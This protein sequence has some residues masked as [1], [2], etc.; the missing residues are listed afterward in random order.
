MHRAK[1]FLLV[2]AAVSIS[3]SCVEDKEF[4][5]SSMKQILE[6]SSTRTAVFVSFADKTL[7]LTVREENQFRLLLTDY[8]KDF[9]EE[10]NYWIMNDPM[11]PTHAPDLRVELYLNITA[12]ERVRWQDLTTVGREPDLCLHVY[13]L[14]PNTRDCFLELKANVTPPPKKI[15][16]LH[17]NG[18]ITLGLWM[19]N[20]LLRRG[21]IRVCRHMDSS[22]GSE[23]DAAFPRPIRITHHRAG[24][25]LGEMFVILD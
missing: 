7:F 22:R 13:C 18:R 24:T 2:F 11:T 1:I 8:L 3:C 16:T 14:F 21:I 17:G 20:L 9:H 19:E 10:R 23:T 5:L 6:S 12:D 25:A 15:H 4:E